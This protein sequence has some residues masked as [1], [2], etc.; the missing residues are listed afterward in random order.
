D[1]VGIEGLS[2]ASDL[3][4]GLSTALTSYDAANHAAIMANDPP[5]RAAEFAAIAR[6]L[7][8]I[9]PQ[10]RDALKSRLR[11]DDHG[12]EGQSWGPLALA[13]LTPRVIEAYAAAFAEDQS[14]LFDLMSMLVTHHSHSD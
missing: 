10:G 5:D 8:S 6:L 1:F 12:E 7:V 3:V 14:V 2:G 13:L 11:R 4:F 9:V